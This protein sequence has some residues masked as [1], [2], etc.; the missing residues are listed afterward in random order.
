MMN[1]S[2][3]IRGRTIMTGAP[4]TDA[5]ISAGSCYPHFAPAASADYTRHPSM[6][7]F[8]FHAIAIS[9][10]TLVWGSA[11]IVT[12]VLAPRVNAMQ[13][14]ARPW[15][16]LIAWTC[17]VRVSA[18]GLDNIPGNSAC[19][20]MSNHQSHFDAVALLMTLPGSY[21]IL[22]KRELFYIPVFGWALW[23]AGMIPVNR[24]RRESAIRS[25]DHAAAK[26]REGKSIVVFAEGTRSED[27]RLQPFKKGG[28]HMALKSGAPIVPITVSGSREVLPKGRLRIMPGKI[29]VRI[30]PPIP[31]TRGDAVGIDEVMEDVR[32]A[33]S[34]CLE[35]A[36]GTLSGKSST[37]G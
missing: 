19:V 22:A 14:F 20:F 35:T 30:G 26:V 17:G 36:P 5:A 2:W 27:G 4:T 1:D 13:R 32:R 11:A 21:A 10:Y 7:R 34:A 28:F 6:L 18:I 31:T 24:S 8:I 23:L 9:L 33:M 15:A 37:I 16:R 3:P 12:L 25:L 29:V